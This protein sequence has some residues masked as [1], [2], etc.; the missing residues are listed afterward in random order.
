M[1]VPQKQAVEDKLLLNKRDN[2]YG[3]WDWAGG[4]DHNGYDIMYIGDQIYSVPQLSAWLWKGFDFPQ[5]VPYGQ[6]QI[7]NLV[8][9]CGNNLCYNPDHLQALNPQPLEE[10]VPLLK[11]ASSGHY[12]PESSSPVLEHES[13]HKEK[14]LENH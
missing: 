11:S 5:P 14:K 2:D 1:P 3:C 10:E 12:R 8:K 9:T 13:K 7:L 6:T 4:H